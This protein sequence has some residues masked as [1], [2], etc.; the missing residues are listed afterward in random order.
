MVNDIE[1]CSEYTVRFGSSSKAR[2]QQCNSFGIQIIW[3]IIYLCIH[4][5]HIPHLYLKTKKK[6]SKIK[7]FNVVIMEKS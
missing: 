5:I 4:N 3:K 2:Y 6:N 7:T 1:R